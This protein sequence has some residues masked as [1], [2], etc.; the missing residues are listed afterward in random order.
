MSHFLNLGWSAGALL[1][2]AM[3]LILPAAAAEPKKLAFVVGIDR[4]DNLSTDG[5]LKKA[6]GD[7]R[8]MA[9]TLR[10][11]GF[12]VTEVPEP[13]RGQFVAEWYK[14]LERVAEGDTI[15]FVFSG[16]GVELEGTN[17]LLPRDVPRARSGREGQL[18]S[19]SISFGQ[20]LTD[21]RERKPAFSFV[22][23]DACRDN[24]FAEGEKSVG[25]K[26][27]LGRVEPLEGTFVMFSAGAGQTA[28]DRLEGYDPVPTSV[29]TRILL[30][31]MRQPGLSLLDM[32]D[33]VGE[34]V[35]D[36]AAKQ[37]HRQTP[38]FYS[39]VTGARRVCLAGCGAEVAPPPSAAAREWNDVKASEDIAVLQAFR[40][41]HQG[42]AVY[43]ALAD[44][45]I[46]ALTEKNCEFARKAGLDPRYVAGCATAPVVSAPREPEAGRNGTPL[47]RE[48]EARKPEP[49]ARG[50]G[51][52]G[53]MRLPPIIKSN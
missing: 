50:G 26:R 23:L 46:A 11:L 17:F 8:A 53:A 15:A 22:V 38:A 48:P 39:R 20:I 18:R 14:F 7:A 40:N 36:L 28:L 16:H 52:N 19:E 2:M 10:Q 43:A 13:T 32:A 49:E 9:G 31:L 37:G 3:C 21:M 41:R 33:Q 34:Q 1:L 51:S 4:Y 45:A 44:K 12:S 42:D 6:V 29:F 30:P 47:K 27:G 5:Q 35:R 24:P 25:S